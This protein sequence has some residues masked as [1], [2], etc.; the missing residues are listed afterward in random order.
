MN[1]HAP[2]SPPGSDSG[3][4]LLRFPLLMMVATA[5]VLLVIAAFS[6]VL[7]NR[8]HT[9]QE[10]GR[11]NLNVA[12]LVGFHTMYVLNSS[13]LLLDSVADHV[14][15]KGFAY[16]QSEE[17]KRFLQTRTQDYPDLQSMLLID[18]YGQLL[19]GATL[20]FPPPRVNYGDR[21][22]FLA[23]VGGQDLVL[24]EQLVSRTQG[25]RG[26][27][28]SRSIRSAD[29]TFE[30]IVLL[31]IES[32]HFERMFQSV[33]GFGNEEITVFRDDGAIFA[34]YPEVEVGRRY[35][36]AS[37][38]AKARELSSGIY[39][40]T[41]V[42]DERLR[43]VAFERLGDF[44]LVVVSSQLRDEVLASWWSFCLV[45]F[46]VLALALIWLGA[47][48]RYAFRTVLHNERLQLE[49]ARLARTDALTDLANRRHFAELAEKELARALRYGTSVAVLMVDI[50][51]FKRINDTHGH[52]AGDEVLRQL[53]EIFRLT[54]RNIDVVGRLGG[55]EFAIVLAQS[56][57]DSGLEVAERLRIAIEQQGVLLSSGILLHYTVSVGVT[58]LAGKEDSVERLLKRADDALYLAKNG[59][60]NTVRSA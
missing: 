17:G 55:E 27:T 52:A 40:A 14:R 26:A 3:H 33:R 41:S 21:D 23:H 13:V 36:Q 29:G 18:R 19:V 53:G 20:P 37:V 48:G 42:F 31:T 43:L 34:R 51:H 9:L 7:E 54:L 38:F 35:P 58:A 22:Y 6:L 10:A 8:R 11:E 25:R 12:R 2:D 56:G 16:F 1:G 32:S 44:P 5:A 47:A 28:I 30:G 24:G 57:L 4:Q 46:F 39:E 59:G 15:K 49:L 60:R 45:V 50:D